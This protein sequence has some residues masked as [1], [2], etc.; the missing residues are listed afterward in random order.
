MNDDDVWSY[1]KTEVESWEAILDGRKQV[2][3][4]RLVHAIGM[5]N[6]NCHF[7]I[8]WWLNDDNHRNNFATAPD[9]G[10]WNDIQE[11]V[12]LG[13]MEQWRSIPGGLIYFHV[14]VAGIRL[15]KANY[16]RV[17]SK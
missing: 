16:E 4:G 1:I 7:S 15:A 5:N 13:L 9:C 14:T 6:R 12:R 2:L 8:R 11:L 17:G 3:L 10:H